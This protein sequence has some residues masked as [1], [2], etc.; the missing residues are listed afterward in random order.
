MKISN[1]LLW[2]VIPIVLC[3]TTILSSCADKTFVPPFTSYAPLS[4]QIDRY[5]LQMAYYRDA[6][7]ADAIYSGKRYYFGLVR[8]EQTTSIF[9]V[10]GSEDY[11]LVENVK[12]IA[13]ASYDIKGIIQGTVFEV[14]GD[15]QG[16]QSGYIIVKNCWFR[17]Q[18]GGATF[19]SGGAY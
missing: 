15:V 3:I 18:S 13:R 2:A 6:A 10:R 12:F 9:G 7:A 4:Q 16:M 19:P 14:I 1:K 17:I 8:A 5:Q 11:V